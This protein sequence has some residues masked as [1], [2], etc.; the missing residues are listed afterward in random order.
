MLFCL[1]KRATEGIEREALELLDLLVDGVRVLE[2][3]F[4]LWYRQADA[5]LGRQILPILAVVLPDS[6]VHL[7]LELVHR[8]LAIFVQLEDIRILAGRG[9]SFLRRLWLLCRRTLHMG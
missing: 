9:S 4:P 1:R 7:A 6:H 3:R 2:Q 8:D 5:L